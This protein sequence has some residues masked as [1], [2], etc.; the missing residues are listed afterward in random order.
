MSMLNLFLIQFKKK[1]FTLK[2]LFHKTYF[3]V[4]FELNINY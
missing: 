2:L 4:F 3:W 1:S